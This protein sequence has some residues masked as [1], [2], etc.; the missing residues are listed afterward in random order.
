MEKHTSH[1][2][3]VRDLEQQLL[4]PEVRRSAKA[5]VALLSDEFIEYGSSGRVYNKQQTMENLQHDDSATRTILQFNATTL[6]P[7]VILVTYR[8]TREETGKQPLRTL[9]CS[10]W[11]HIEGRW[12]MVFHQGTPMANNE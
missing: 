7:D 9:R 4:T 10:I 3:V 11:K 8:C 6:A 12:K 2:A 5:T 1:A